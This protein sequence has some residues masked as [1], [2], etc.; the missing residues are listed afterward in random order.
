MYQTWTLPVERQKKLWHWTWHGLE[1]KS[2]WWFGNAQTHLWMD[3]TLQELPFVSHNCWQTLGNLLEPLRWVT[4]GSLWT[5]IETMV[6][7]NPKIKE[8]LF[9]Q[10]HISLKKS[11]FFKF[12]FSPK[13]HI[14]LKI[15]ISLKNSDFSNS[16]F[17][18]NSHF[19]S[20]SHFYSK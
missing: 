6:V 8:L 2:C 9:S 17:P 11:D 16:H 3:W 1:S 10:I 15:N 5:R 7:Y 20:N 19:P 18:Q 12:T 4:F 13:I 14:F